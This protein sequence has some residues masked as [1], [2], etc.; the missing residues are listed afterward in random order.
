MLVCQVLSNIQHYTPNIA[1][2][3]NI[4]VPLTAWPRDSSTGTPGIDLPVSVTVSGWDGAVVILDWQAAS[5]VIRLKDDATI[6]FRKL[7]KN[8]PTHLHILHTL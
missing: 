3:D 6:T 1:V 2:L 8:K 7:G 4:T 5:Q